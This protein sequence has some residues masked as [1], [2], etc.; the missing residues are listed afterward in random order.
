M[1]FYSTTFLTLH[2]FSNLSLIDS[3]QCKDTDNGATDVWGYNCR[4]YDDILDKCGDLD[5]EDF[6]ANTMCCACKNTRK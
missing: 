3:S 4:S 2:S 1:V 6:T 5:D